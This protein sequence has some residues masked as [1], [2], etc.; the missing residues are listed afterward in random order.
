MKQ[1]F[2][3]NKPSVG[4]KL[5]NGV[6]LV[7]GLSHYWL[8]N[9]DNGIKVHNI[10]SDNDHGRFLSTKLAQWAG[11]GGKRGIYLPKNAGL[12]E[13]PAVAGGF[14]KNV[15]VGFSVGLW[16]Y[17]S[18]MSITNDYGFT[19]GTSIQLLGN[20]LGEWYF[21]TS[22]VAYQVTPIKEVLAGKWHYVVGTLSKNTQ[23]LYLNGKL[24]ARSSG[25][26]TIPNPITDLIFGGL[27]DTSGNFHGYIDSVQLWQRPI[28]EG[29]VKWSYQNPYGMAKYSN[30]LLIDSIVETPSAPTSV[31]AVAGDEQV[32]VSW[33]AV[34]GATSYNIY[35]KTSSPVTQ[36]NGTKITGVT[37]PYIHTG[38]TNGVPIYYV[39]T[40]V[41]TGGESADSSEVN[42]TP[43]GATIGTWLSPVFSANKNINFPGKRFIWIDGTFDDTEV[44]ANGDVSLK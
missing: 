26:Y 39:V 4:C 18:D 12:I 1:K 21:N 15:N 19:V 8:M 40:A 7:K 25:S 10:V 42:A 34:A 44:N 13:V 27:S 35:W 22:A 5:N 9:E 43:T 33:D 36:L 24:V 6:N 2:R 30:I 31:S 32:T 17:K 3:H 20:Y 16:F 37:S 11:A 14:I 29:E 38:L 23:C 41:G 28:S